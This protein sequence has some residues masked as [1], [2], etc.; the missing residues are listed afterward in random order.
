MGPRANSLRNISAKAASAVAEKSARA[1]GETPA[2]AMI[3]DLKPLIAPYRERGR[4]TIRIENLPQSARLSA[5]QNNGDRTWSLAQD[6]LEELSYFPPPGIDEDHALTVRLIAK[7]ET[8][9]STIAVLEVRPGGGAKAEAAP[10]LRLA[11]KNGPA[12]TAADDNLRLELAQL[13]IDL[14]SREQE[15]GKLHAAAGQDGVL[16][17]QLEQVKTALAARE[18]ELGQLRAVLEQ[19]GTQSQEKIDAAVWA[20]ESIWSR[21]E[22]ARLNALRAELQ[23]QIE[24]QA[25]TERRAEKQARAGQE[26]DAAAIRQVHGELARAQQLL[27]GQDSELKR[28]LAEVEQAKRAHDAEIAGVRQA[29]ESQAAAAAQRQAE[30]EAAQA[31]IMARWETTQAALAAA[32]ASGAE[33]VQQ[34]QAELER[35]RQECQSLAAAKVAA[36]SMA[37]ERLKSAQSQ[38]EHQTAR[39]LT[40]IATRCEVAEVALAAARAANV[41]DKRPNDQDEVMQLR[42]ELDRLRQEA[43]AARESMDASIAERLKTA[44]SQWEEETA[45]ALGEVLMRCEAAEQALAAAR[46]AAPN[47]NRDADLIQLQGELERARRQAQELAQAHADAERRGADTLRSAQAQWQ[48]Q[49]TQTLMEITARAQAAEAALAAARIND[50]SKTESDAY[51]RSLN[52]EVKTLQAALVDREAAL[53]HAQA[54]LEQLRFGAEARGPAAQWRPLQGGSYPRDEREVGGEANSHLMRD[55]AILFLIVLVSVLAFPRIEAMLPDNIRWQIET[56]GGLFVPAGGNGASAPVAAPAEHVT[57]KTEHLATVTRGMNLRDQPSVNG[58]LVASLKRGARVAILETRGNWDRISIAGA[59]GEKDLQGWVYNTYIQDGIQDGIQA[60][61]PAA[62]PAGAQAGTQ[63]GTQTGTPAGTPAGA[64]AGA[65]AD[66]RAG[67]H[68]DAQGGAQAGI[69]DAPPAN[70]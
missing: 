10:Q 40:D 46:A 18:S 33:A 34:Q 37:A 25:E 42:A 55:V 56:G 48:Q 66:T 36:E 47:A 44:Q 50:S 3:L 41:S 70:N 28:L 26:Q 54:S 9:A 6:E 7:D 67:V 62:N 5:G 53:A 38:W 45:K 15:L 39:A 24:R 61:T 32:Q 12:E 60:A 23:A 68:A 8:G 16:R 63:T 29:A 57:P 17:Q 58:A 21:D 22:Q 11:R 1:A 31:D 27:T 4:L 52:R 13:K 51:I 65:Q 49:T 14:A 2:R 43:S 20:A 69:Q 30:S 59:A 64:Q 19:A 35:L